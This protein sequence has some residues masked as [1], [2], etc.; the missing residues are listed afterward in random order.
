[1]KTYDFKKQQATFYTTNTTP[2]YIEIPKMNYIMIQGVGDPNDENGEYKKAIGVLFALSYAIKMS[3]KTEYQIPGYFPYVV[4]PFEGLWTFQDENTTFV[5]ENKGNMSWIAM[6]H[7]PDFVNEEVFQWACKQVQQKKKLDTSKAYLQ[8]FEEGLCIQM[9]HIGHY[10]DEV[11]SFQKMEDKIKE[12]GYVE[13]F[14]F[15][16]YHHH[17]IYVKD[18]R[19]PDPMKW[20]TILRQKVK[21]A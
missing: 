6:I 9:L 16:V 18:N 10:D 13:D 11:Q 21:K 4:P 5:K 20:K 1:M 8:E 3:Y 7:Q 12:D 14:Q 2:H 17:E 19:E 15:H